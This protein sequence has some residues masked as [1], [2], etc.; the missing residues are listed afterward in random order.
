ML[1]SS[2]FIQFLV[3]L[4]EQPQVFPD[5]QHGVAII[6]FVLNKNHL[7]LEIVLE[8]RGIDDVLGPMNARLILRRH[9]FEIQ[10]EMNQMSEFILFANV[11]GLRIRVIF[12]FVEDARKAT[13][14]LVLVVKLKYTVVKESRQS[15]RKIIEASVNRLVLLQFQIRIFVNCELVNKMWVLQ[16]CLR[17]NGDHEGILSLH[18]FEPE[19]RDLV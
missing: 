13:F 18:D 9:S 3:L 19:P 8:E 6:S 16:F 14:K 12:A 4:S 5:A 11:H 2:F 17:N 10:L 15:F 1:D 7:L